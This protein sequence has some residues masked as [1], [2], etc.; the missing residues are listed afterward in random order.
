MRRSVVFSAVGA[1]GIG[2]Q[3]GVLWVLAGQLGWHYLAATVVATETAVLHNFVWHI[4]WTWADRPASVPGTL[5][6]LVRFHVTNGVVSLAGSA[7][8]MTLL[9]GY[10][11][12]HYLPAN[13]VSILVCAVVNLW[14]SDTVV[15]RREWKPGT[16]L[17][18]WFVEDTGCPPRS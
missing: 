18:T 6:R 8:V 16:C 17:E 14:L 12:I 9:T 11:R 7:A 5:A 13:I 3:L 2:V 15:F 4:R 1:L 10:L